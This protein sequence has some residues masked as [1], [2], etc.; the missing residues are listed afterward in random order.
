MAK[1]IRKAWVN[2]TLGLMSVLLLGLLTWRA[3]ELPFSNAESADFLMHREH[4]LS[5]MFSA[6]PVATPLTSLTVKLSALFLGESPLALRLPGL[7]GALLYFW[8]ATALAKNF[9]LPITQ[10]MVFA[11]L[12]LQVFVFPWLGLALGYGLG[13]SF[14]LAA[15]F[16]F[17]K[18]R[19]MDNGHHIWRACIFMALSAGAH[20]VFLPTYLALLLLFNFLR[21][22]GSHHKK[23]SFWL[24]NRPVS[25]VSFFL[26]AFLFSAYRR[27]GTEFSFSLKAWRLPLRESLQ[28]PL[29]GESFWSEVLIGLSL[30]A[31]LGLFIWDSLRRERPVKNRMYQELLLWILAASLF[32]ALVEGL[33]RSGLLYLSPVWG[34]APLFLLLAPFVLQ[35][36]NDHPR[37]EKWQIGLQSALSGGSA[38]LFALSF[39]LRQN[40]LW[41]HDQ[42]ND[43]VWPQFVAYCESQALD[44]ADCL[45]VAPP[46]SLAAMQYYQL[47]QYPQQN[48]RVA[49]QAYKAEC[50][51]HLRHESQGQPEPALQSWGKSGLYLENQA[52]P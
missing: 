34:F 15:L 22:S 52:N 12:A 7:L 6:N 26:A 2:W 17:H 38:L 14:A 40:A 30:A 3:A 42:V 47:R 25:I 9:R 23:P 45:L 28:L 27:H 19:Q 32:Q 51:L 21:W 41:P 8:Y 13:F 10:I 16:H 18:Y 29:W 43:A 4:S 36:F 1:Q 48:L 20:L 39:S 37:G 35:R 11:F 24:V 49:S 31:A 46:E 5:Q 44:P 50:R 33:L